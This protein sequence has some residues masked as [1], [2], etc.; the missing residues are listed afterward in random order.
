[1]SLQDPIA[2]MLTRIRNAQNRRKRFVRMPFSRMKSEIA[3]VLKDEGYIDAFY[4]HE[5]GAKRQLEVVIKYYAGSPVMSEIKRISRPGLRA[6]R[7]KDEL[8]RVYNGLGIAIVS[9][10]EGIMT[11]KDARQR[12]IG[13][14][15]LCSVF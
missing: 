8:D 13:G 3:R 9:T 5:E 6:Y 12:G 14:E 7:G 2:D 1:M 11:D 4:T 15:I 10:S